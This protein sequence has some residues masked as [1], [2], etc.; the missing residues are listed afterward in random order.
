MYLFEDSDSENSNITES[1][2]ENEDPPSNDNVAVFRPKKR[3][4]QPQLHKKAILKKN[5][6]RGEA[7]TSKSGKNI[8]AKVF[9]IQCICKCSRQC[10]VVFDVVRQKEIFDG[11]YK[12]SNWSQKTLFIR[13]C[14]KSKNVQSKRSQQFPILALKNRNITCEYHIPDSNGNTQRVCWD[15]FLNC[16]KVPAARVHKALKTAVKNPSATELRGAQ[17]SVNETS[18]ENRENVKKFIASLPTYESHYGRTNS[19]KR[20]LRHG[21]NIVKLYQEYKNVMEFRQQDNVHPTLEVIHHKFFVVGHSYNSCDRSFSTIE[22]ARKSTENLYAPD[23][24][25]ELVQIAKKTNPKFVV[26]K[27]TAEDFFSTCDLEMDITNRK[28]DTNNKK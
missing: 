10:P 8:P 20:Y 7:H 26:T 28:K 27:M 3:L 23:Q 1:D 24:W 4:R 25:I 9:K 11:F 6:E 5:V 18:A 15:F 21:L 2:R 12:E 17:A 16:L 22:R 14:V 19:K 13:A